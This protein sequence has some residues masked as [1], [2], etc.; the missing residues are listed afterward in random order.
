MPFSLEFVQNEAKCTKAKKLNFPCWTIRIVWANWRLLLAT[1]N[2]R[3]QLLDHILLRIRDIESPDNGYFIH[4]DAADASRA[5]GHDW[6]VAIYVS[7]YPL[8]LTPRFAE[9]ARLQRDS[10]FEYSHFAL[11]PVDSSQPIAGIQANTS[12]S[13]PCLGAVRT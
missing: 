5:V 1:K 4:L 2:V 12:L 3:S 11:V 13:K 10:G 8:Q 9:E 7:D 6:L